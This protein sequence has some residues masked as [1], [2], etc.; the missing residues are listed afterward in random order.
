MFCRGP[1][2]CKNL[3]TVTVIMF[4][5]ILEYLFSDIGYSRQ[6]ATTLAKICTCGSSLPQGGVTSPAIANLVAS[7]LDRRIAG[8]CGKK[9]IVYTR[10]ADDLTFSTNNRNILNHAEE[11]LTSIIRSE[12][13]EVNSE[14]TRFSGPRVCCSVTGLIKN[15]SI[16]KFGIGRKKKLAMRSVIFNYIVNDKFV[17]PK[18]GTK[19]SIIGW[20]NYCNNVDKQVYCSLKRYANRLDTNNELF[21]SA[22][23]RAVDTTH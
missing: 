15:S 3:R 17:N 4:R 12:G 14:K 22:S 20:L 1:I 21:N 2:P 16:P 6:I 18:Y 5:V 19:Q 8:Y 7:R 11:I 10:Y 9:K 23:T 13:Y